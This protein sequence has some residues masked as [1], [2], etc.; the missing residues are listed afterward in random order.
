MGLA[1][2]AWWAGA[3]GGGAQR[4]GVSQ[5]AF[6]GRL[7]HAPPRHNLHTPQPN[8][9]R[10]SSPL[11]ITRNARVPRSR[12]VGSPRGQLPAERRGREGQQ[13]AGGPRWLAV[14]AEKAGIAASP[15]LQSCGRAWHSLVDVQE[16]SAQPDRSDR[17]RLSQGTPAQGRQQLLS[18]LPDARMHTTPAACFLPT[19][20]PAGG[21]RRCGRCRA[22]AGAGRPR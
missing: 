18:P 16:Q 10:L 17:S 22:G 9:T 6:L 13:G 19:E 2:S 15:S 14:R 8:S 12:V 3:G 5:V 1:G 7:L 20:A 11:R 21:C 4:A